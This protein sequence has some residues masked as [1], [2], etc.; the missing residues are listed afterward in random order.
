[1][2][3]GKLIKDMKK[4]SLEGEKLRSSLSVYEIAK[5]DNP[6]RP[7]EKAIRIITVGFKNE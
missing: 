1:M 3:Q 4:E 5:S 2:I 7:C 6:S